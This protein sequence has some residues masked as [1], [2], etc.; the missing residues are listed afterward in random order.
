MTNLP[1]VKE[2]SPNVIA[3][4]IGAGATLFAAL[5]NLRI[6]WRREVLDRLNRPRSPRKRRGLLLA[7]FILM[8]ASGVGGYAGALYLMQH[9]QQ[10]THALR[11]DLQQ[12]IAQIQE[13]A[14]RLEQAR[15][16][17]LNALEAEARRREERRRAEEGIVAT[18]RIGPCAARTT[19][20][21]DDAA[22][23]TA[24]SEADAVPIAVCATVP[25]RATVYEVAP[26]VR[27]EGEAAPWSERRV[28][29]GALVRGKSGN[30]RL[31]ALPVERVDG[32]HSKQVCL[33]VRSWESEHAL[34]VRVVVKFFLGDTAPANVPATAPA[35]PV[36][37]AVDVTR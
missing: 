7:I 27:F 15:L 32:E 31:G 29:L 5:I 22:R 23:A 9:E 14:V 37:A 24:C 33:D 21:G 36:Q 12:R 6:A 20:T 34:D 4:L 19:T 13:T 28:A 2:L 16:G 8:A 30:A 26:H 17:E 1:F 25:T 18:T 3:A 11:T 35:P 10:N